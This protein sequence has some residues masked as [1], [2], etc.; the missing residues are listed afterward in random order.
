[1]LTKQPPSAARSIYGHLGRGLYNM[2]TSSNY[3]PA[4][5]RRGQ[6]IRYILGYN[7]KRSVADPFSVYKNV[8]VLSHDNQNWFKQTQFMYRE[9]YKILFKTNLTTILV[10]LYLL[11][12]FT[13]VYV[14]PALSLCVAE[15]DT[16]LIWL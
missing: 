6:S 12:D 5:L 11:P 9:S 16:L 10:L 8:C 3:C 13:N 4:R 15:S 1:M 7:N 2:A 14:L